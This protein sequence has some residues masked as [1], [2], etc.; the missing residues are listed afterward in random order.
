M[1]DFVR[2]GVRFVAFWTAYALS[3]VVGLLP[4][5]ENLWAFGAGGGRRFGENTK[6]LFLHVAAEHPDVR[7]VWLSKDPD[8]IETVR[9]A[10]YE[11]YR[12]SSL[13]GLFYT[14]RAKFLFLS[15]GT[16]DVTW[17]VTGAPTVV[18]LWHGVPLKRIGLTREG[19]DWGRL[20]RF[21]FE[22]RD[23]A[24][25]YLTVTAEAVRDVSARAYE[26]SPDR[27]LPTGYPRND[28]LLRDVPDEELGSE[29]A[30]ETVRR[31][32]EEERVVAYMP[33]YRRGFAEGH[34]D[35]I[36]D[37]GINFEL[38]N[39]LLRERDAHFVVKYHPHATERVDPGRHE[40]IHVLPDDADIY[41][42]LSDVDV[43][44][45]DY[46]SVYFDYLLLDR[47]VVF[48]PYDLDAYRENPGFYFDYDDVTP[49]PTARS[50]PEL[51]ETLE[52]TLDGEDEY[53]AER[54]EV[55]DRFF[56]HAD[57]ESAERVYRTFR[58]AD[59]GSAD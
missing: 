5:R 51:V 28:A 23:S 13:R 41:P 55:R 15:L 46:S 20:D 14:L 22:Y 57:A 39:A 37:A 11:A 36:A 25:D 47:P 32:S 12:A 29:D 16:N 40:R 56:D 45:T 17:W 6:Y 42:L 9:D 2:D 30:V 50:F 49:G 34:G 43:L 48:F 58:S 19:K 26:L 54:R 21:R 59:G 52:A 35:S 10:G 18:Q 53:A 24:W 27:V 33:T 4:A 7:P 31:L 3:Y 38:L 44:V 8:V 1:R